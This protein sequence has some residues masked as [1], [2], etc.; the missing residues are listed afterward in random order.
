[1]ECVECVVWG[2]FSVGAATMSSLT[3]LSYHELE[4]EYQRDDLELMRCICLEWRRRRYAVAVDAPPELDWQLLCEGCGGPYPCLGCLP[5]N[6][7]G[8]DSPIASTRCVACNG[9]PM[10]ET[11]ACANCSGPRFTGACKWCNG[12][13]R[14]TTPFAVSRSLGAAI[15][16]TQL[17]KR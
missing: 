11:N 2:I 17:D 5:C 8:D 13:G 10:Q 9:D 7:C 6:I 16:Q 4:R 12:T 3:S 1:M 14:V 15:R